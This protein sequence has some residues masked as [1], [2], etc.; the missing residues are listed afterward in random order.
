[1]FIFMVEELF[2]VNFIVEV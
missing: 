2:N 1:M